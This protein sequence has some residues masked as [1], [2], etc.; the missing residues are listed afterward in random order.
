M[1]T[2][3]ELSF[4]RKLYLIYVIPSLI[5]HEL[6]HILF[7]FLFIKGFKIIECK[8]NPATH[9][10]SVE[11]R[12]PP[13]SLFMQFFVSY[14]PFLTMLFFLTLAFT[15]NWMWLVF[16]YQVTTDTAL[17]SEQDLIGFEETFFDN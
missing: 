3:K 11:L 14:A 10:W 5:I 2:F 9:H 4:K 12:Q 17:P 7:Y 13:L 1:K 16:L 8:Y 15:Y 6:S